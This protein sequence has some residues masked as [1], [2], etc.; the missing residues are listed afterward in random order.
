MVND[1]S[2]G[3]KELIDKFTDKYFITFTQKEAGFTSKVEEHIIEVEMKESTY[4]IAEQ[5]E[6]DKVVQGKSGVILADTPAKMMQ[7]LHQIYSGTC[8]LEDGVSITLDNSKA[9]A[10]KE[11]FK[12]K[13]IGIF[14]KFVHEKEMLKEVFGDTLCFDLDEFNSTDKNIALQIVSGRE[15]ISLRKADYLVFI[16]IDFSATSYFQA[17]DRMTTIDRLENTVY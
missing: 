9:I 7:K 2:Q 5:L 11:K 12:G 10:I 17:L 8:K 14:Y 16:N 3:N 6:K 15:G 13:K 4:K 1:Y